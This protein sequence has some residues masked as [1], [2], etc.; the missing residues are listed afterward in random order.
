MNARATEGRIVRCAF[1]VAAG[2]ALAA[3]PATGDEGGTRIVTLKHEAACN[4][5]G[6]PAPKRQT[7]LV[8]DEGSVL[9]SGPEEF[10]SRNPGVIDAVLATADPEK[11]VGLGALEPR[12]RVSVFVAPADGSAPRLM[13]SGCAPAVTDEELASAESGQSA[14]KRGSDTFFASGLKAQVEEQASEYRTRLLGAIQHIAESAPAQS[15]RP[16]ESFDRSPLVRSLQAAVRLGDPQAGVPRIV[17]LAPSA[18]RSVGRYANGEAARQAGFAA[19]R[20][21]NLNLGMAQVEVA[22]AS[23]DSR[24]FIDAFL[25]GSR[26]RLESWSSQTPT[27]LRPAPA[28]V[29]NFSGTIQYGPVQFPVRV[30]LAMDRKGELANSWIEVLNEGSAATPLTG[31]ATCDANGDC[32]VSGDGS[33]FSQLWSTKPGGQPEFGPEV[34]FSGLRYFEF[35]VSRGK[36]AGRVYDPLVDQ[37]GGVPDLRF[38]MKEVA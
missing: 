33:G 26:A 8:I 19:A 29:R 35:R 2:L 31:H 20:A 22:L 24:D 6:L 17:L 13:F 18:L 15:P 1:I 28:A 12:E 38:E 3:C 11:A 4:L 23:A 37:V 7:L 25:L 10:R 34:P 16:A 30:R 9:R 27:N 5:A 36:A 21:T 14:L 32:L